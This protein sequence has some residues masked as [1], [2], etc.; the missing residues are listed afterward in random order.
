MA[1]IELFREADFRKA[2]NHLSEFPAQRRTT[3]TPLVCMRFS[4]AD[5]A[6]SLTYK[7]QTP[8]RN[9]LQFRLQFLVHRTPTRRRPSPR[10]R[11]PFEGR[12]DRSADQQY[13]EAYGAESGSLLDLPYL[14]VFE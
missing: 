14:S 1:T 6:V 12:L 5:A 7:T 4:S 2:V 9:G 13:R 11:L 8:F 10:M 3:A